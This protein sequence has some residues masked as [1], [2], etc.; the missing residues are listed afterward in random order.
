MTVKILTDSA[1]DLPLHFY[2]ENHVT[3]FP[4]KVLLNEKEYE[5]Q[6]SIKTKS[7]L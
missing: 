3:F 2:E 5:D 7:N 4:L 6:L 1:C